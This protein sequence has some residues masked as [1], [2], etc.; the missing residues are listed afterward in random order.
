M[1]DRHAD[2]EPR[3]PPRRRG[4]RAGIEL[5]V[6]SGT[7][8]D[9]VDGQLAARPGG[10]GA[11]APAA[12]P[13]LGGLPRRSR[14]ARGWSTG[15]TASAEEDAALIA[16]RAADGRAPRGA[17]PEG[18]DRLGAPE[19]PQDRSDPRAGVGRSA[20]GADRRA[21]RRRGAPAGGRRHRRPRRRGRDRARRRDR[22]RARRPAGDQRRQARRDR[23]HRQVRLGSLDR[24]RAVAR[25]IGPA[26]CSSSATSSGRSAACPAATPTCWCEARAATAVS[27]GVEPAGFPPTSSR[28]AAA[29]D[30]SSAVLEDQ[31][32]RRRRGELPVVDADPAWTLTR[33]RRRSAARARARVAA[34]ARRRPAR[35]ARQRRSRRIRAGDPSVLLSGVY[36]G[37]GAETALL[38]APR[39]NT[40]AIAR[41]SSARVAPRAR[42]A[43]RRAAPQRAAIGDADGSTRCSLSSLAR[44]ATA[45]LR[46]RGPG[47]RASAPPGAAAATRRDAAQTGSGDGTARGCASRDGRRLDRRRGHDAR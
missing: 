30:A 18:R 34:H 14:R 17:R 10:P 39:W 28:S 47:A 13:R 12:Q 2:A 41:S 44:P 25:G 19:P 36:T 45:V 8:V 11:A 38:P 4:L 5:A 35:D 1:P 15:A 27:V 7:H 40:V 3:A 31:I 43:H 42:P 26:R 16:R 32:A 23:P 33:R 24:P 37:T 46:V 6:V 9:N 21:A 20:E 29:R 22:G